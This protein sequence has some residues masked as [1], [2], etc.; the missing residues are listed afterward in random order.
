MKKIQ[1]RTRPSAGVATYTGWAGELI[2][3]QTNNR[4]V[5]QD[6]ATAGGWPAAKLSEVLSNTPGSANKFMATPNG[7]T[8]APSLRAIATGDLPFATGSGNQILATPNGS[9]GAP[10]LR[11]LVTADLP[12]ATGTANQFLATPNGSAGAPSLRPIATGDLPF[13]TGPANA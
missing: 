10:S 9:G 7:S 8:G 1:I 4:L 5:L 2:V 6:G 11:A 3:D 12:F 13:A